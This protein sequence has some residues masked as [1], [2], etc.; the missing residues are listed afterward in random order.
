M[1]V[2]YKELGCKLVL[3][4]GKIR[5]TLDKIEAKFGQI[6]LDLGKINIVHPEKH[7]IHGYEKAR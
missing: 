4:M 6:W 3:D 7:S 5:Q 2:P 1:V